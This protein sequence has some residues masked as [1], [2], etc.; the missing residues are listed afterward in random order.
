MAIVASVVA[1]LLAGWV[2]GMWTR[3]RSN[4][5]CPVDGTTLSCPQCVSAG[6]N[7]STAG[8]RRPPSTMDGQA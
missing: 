1:G 2:G 3:K 5:W 7:V 4:L 8:A 6:A